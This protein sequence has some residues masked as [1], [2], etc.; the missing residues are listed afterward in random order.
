MKRILFLLFLFAL[1]INVI[2]AQVATISIETPS[3]NGLS[4][5]QVDDFDVNTDGTILNNSATGGTAQLGNT[6]VAANPNITAGSEADLIL[7]QVTGSSNSG[8]NGTIE[9]FGGEAG[10]IIANPN[11]IDCDGCGFINTN[12]VDLVTGTANFSGDDL[13]GFSIDGSSTLT[14]SGSGFLSD[15]V[16]DELKLESQNIIIN[17]QVRA[18]DSL[19]IIVNNYTQSGAIDI[20]GDLSIQVSA[21]ASLDDNASIKAKNLFFSAYD[22]YNQA[23]ITITEN[24][25]FDI[26][27]DFWNGFYFD[28]IREGGDII[29][30]SFNVTAGGY[31][32]NQYSATISADSFNVTT[33]RNF[34][35]WGSV[36][37][38][39]T[40]SADSFNVTAGYNFYNWDRATI[41]ADSFNVTAGDDFYNWDRA[42][43]NAN[44]FNAAGYNFNNR[45]NATINADSF[46]VTAGSFFFNYDSAT[47][48]ADS[49]NVTAG[50]DFN[51]Y[52]SEMTLTI[53]IVQQS[54]RITLMLQQVL[55]GTFIIMIVQQSMRIL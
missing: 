21:E 43:I 29:A 45:D 4:N 34:Y 39:V 51:N 8:L 53:M 24:A 11:G 33:D 55:M 1:S 42:T 44:D 25:T 9:V 12:R 54:M 49:F 30:D 31:F 52:D 7:F 50:D 36:W 37:G 16:A 23:D 5:N 2:L 32:I 26:G 35:N 18:N 41:N 14:V 46:N 3:S 17:A 19:E 20:A 48:N 28:G 15:A 27:N 13:T 40:I 10:L 47:I 6:A 38:S 22:L